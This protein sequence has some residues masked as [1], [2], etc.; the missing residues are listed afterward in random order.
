MSRPARPSS[1]HRPS[2]ELHEAGEA[3]RGRSDQALAASGIYVQIYPDELVNASR[4]LKV[5]ASVHG[6]G[7]FDE[8]HLVRSSFW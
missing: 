2:S 6:A 1:A 5:A 4:M 7:L 8:T 3:H